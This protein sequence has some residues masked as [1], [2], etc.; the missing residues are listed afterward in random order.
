MSFNIIYRLT[1]IFTPIKNREILEIS[2]LDISAFQ[3][4]L[5]EVYNFKKKFKQN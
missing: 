5:T 2:G 3:L 4:K 1:L